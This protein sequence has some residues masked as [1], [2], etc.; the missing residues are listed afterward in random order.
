MSKKKKFHTFTPAQIAW[1]VLETIAGR[2]RPVDWETRDEYT[3]QTGKKLPRVENYWG[4]HWAEV[5]KGSFKVPTD[6]RAYL[7]HLR[8]MW[9]R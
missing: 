8:R 2:L 6:R 5:A 3:R 4:R 1:R 9:G 7:D